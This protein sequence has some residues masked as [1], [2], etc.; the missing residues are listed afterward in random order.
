MAG[1][2][3]WLEGVRFRWQR[4]GLPVLDIER[5]VVERAERVLLRGASGSGKTTLL[6]LLAGVAVPEAGELAILGKSLPKLSG[7]KRD[8][9]RADHIGFVFQLFN[10]LPYLDMVAN[11][12]LPCRFSAARRVRAS[13]A[14]GSPRAEAERLLAHMGLPVATFGGRAVSQLSVGQ[15]QRVAAARALIGSPDLI[16]ADE[17]TSAMDAETAEVFL[18]LLFREIRARES[19]LLLVSHERGIERFFDRS[20]ELP[21]INRAAGQAAAMA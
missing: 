21:A 14:S 16:I 5:F 12:T 8:A 13:E 20:V 19:T 1:P 10:L 2:V 9:F 17:P 7:A 3:I 11:V 15:Q 18:D 4:A 6:N